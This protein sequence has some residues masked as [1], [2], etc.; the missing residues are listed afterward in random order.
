M[1]ILWLAV[2]VLSLGSLAGC[3]IYDPHP[4][5]YGPPGGYYYRP[6]RYGYYPYYPYG[7]YR[8]RDRFYGD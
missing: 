7:Y 5:Y 2:L 1:K 6:H 4:Y 8:Y 3:V